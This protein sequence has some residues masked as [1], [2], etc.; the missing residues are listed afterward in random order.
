M[1]SLLSH[2][3]S[4]LPSIDQVE[5]TFKVIR[6]IVWGMFELILLL[7]AMVAIAWEAFSHIPPLHSFL[8]PQPAYSAKPP[9]PVAPSGQP[10]PT[11]P[12]QPDDSPVPPPKVKK[13]R[14]D[15]SVV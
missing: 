4:K 6:F 5:G 7:T 14:C 15:K 12:V 10:V 11:Q 8:D 9:T 1:L 3:L 13:H 2:V